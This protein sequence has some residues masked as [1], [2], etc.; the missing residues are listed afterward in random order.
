MLS[1]S[2][3]SSI[4]QQEG[5]EQ[6]LPQQ[7]TAAAVGRREPAA[8]RGSSNVRGWLTT[9]A[10]VR[11][12]AAAASKRCSTCAGHPSAEA[13]RGGARVRE[14]QGGGSCHLM[15]TD[16]CECRTQQACCAVRSQTAGLWGCGM[17]ARLQDSRCSTAEHRDVH[18]KAHSPSTAVSVGSDE[19]CHALMWLLTSGGVSR[20]WPGS[21]YSFFSLTGFFSSSDLTGFFAFEAPATR[22]RE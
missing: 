17:P 6:Q 15:C 12:L 19:A 18:N 20:V 14:Q 1:S 11:C 3:R 2:Y 9:F 13:G 4:P 10:P 22:Q 16:G 5:A 7:H 21:S 8:R